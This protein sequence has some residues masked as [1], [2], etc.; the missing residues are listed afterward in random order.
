MSAIRLAFA[1]AATRRHIWAMVHARPELLTRTD[2]YFSV[3]P[4]LPRVNLTKSTETPVYYKAP[5]GRDHFT[6][7][8]RPVPLRKMW[9]HDLHSDHTVIFACIQ[10]DISDPELEVCF[11]FRPGPK[12]TEGINAR[13]R[14]VPAADATSTVAVGGV[15]VQYDGNLF[16]ALRALVK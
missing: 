6:F 10:Y 5:D 4:Y 11:Y 8:P 7:Q 16:A 12:G 9:V 1:S 2:T 15:E 3:Q 13:A 14:I